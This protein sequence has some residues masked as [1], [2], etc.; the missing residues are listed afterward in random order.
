MRLVLRWSLRPEDVPRVADRLGRLRRQV[1]VTHLNT[2]FV[3]ARAGHSTFS[4]CFRI[5]RRGC[6]MF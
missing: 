4:S 3:S 6:A 1:H 5:S 2:A